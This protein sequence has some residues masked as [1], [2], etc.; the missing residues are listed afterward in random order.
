MASDIAILPDTTSLDGL[1]G[2]DE[3]LL[4]DFFLVLFNYGVQTPYS[5]KVPNLPITNMLAAG[6]N[7]PSNSEVAQ[8]FNMSRPGFRDLMA[9]VNSRYRD[10]VLMGVSRTA[11]PGEVV[12]TIQIQTT[13]QPV[14]MQRSFTFG[15]YNG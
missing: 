15:L 3:A 6:T 9:K 8:A 13:S 11:N 14:Y 1:V 4:Q 10:A 7:T 2:D 12:L 5:P